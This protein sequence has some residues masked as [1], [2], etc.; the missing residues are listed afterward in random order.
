MHICVS[1]WDAFLS[2]DIRNNEGLLKSG[3]KFLSILLRIGAFFV[4]AI[5]SNPM[6]FIWRE[7]SDFQMVTHG[8]LTNNVSCNLSYHVYTTLL[9]QMSKAF[10]LHWGAL[11]GR[12]LKCGVKGITFHKY[13]GGG[14]GGEFTMTPASLN[15]ISRKIFELR[16]QNVS[17]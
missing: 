8:N 2:M 12:E 13:G 4:I 11:M 5:V 10:V 16:Q 1:P 3:I 17:A 15:H 9:S 14:G 6:F 7:R